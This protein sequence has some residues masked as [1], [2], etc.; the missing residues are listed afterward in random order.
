MGH[1]E[2]SPSDG[3]WPTCHLA[4][5]LDREH[6]KPDSSGRAAER[7]TM[8]HGVGENNLS[9]IVLDGWGDESQCLA[10][11]ES[12]LAE[13]N[14]IDS[15][16]LRVYLHKCL[17]SLTTFN[18]ER[19]NVGVEGEAEIWYDDL[20]LETGTT[21][22][23]LFSQGD[24]IV[25][26]FKS[27]TIPVYAEGNT[28]LV[29]YGWA[30]VLELEA[31][32]EVIER[33]SLEISQPSLPNGGFTY[34]ALT[35]NQL[36][37]EANKLQVAA[38]A[39]NDGSRKAAPGEKTCRWCPH[40]VNCG[41]HVEA[42]KLKLTAKQDIEEMLPDSTLSYLFSKKKEILA[43][44]KLAEEEIRGRI[45]EFSDWKLVAG[46]NKREW[47]DEQEAEDAIELFGVEAIVTT[48]KL[49][50][51]AAAEKQVGKGELDDYIIKTQG[52][53][54]LVP[55]TDKRPPIKEK[56]KEMLTK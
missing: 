42:L 17:T 24:L 38:D 55:S 47:K 44:V 23:W 33:I 31:R 8:L 1:A 27:G 3:R 11:I 40:K 49:L 50:S 46:K 10:F 36:E 43:W 22:F 28:Q 45:D 9:V 26:D 56:I 20:E 54:A 34:W 2:L 29:A 19:H 25:R 39:I 7:G 6:P 16:V 30:Q 51:P 53:P 18:P 32:G 21:D 52:A 13:L 15:D 41:P 35:R 48:T 5:Q 37:I 14:G 4:I 12:S